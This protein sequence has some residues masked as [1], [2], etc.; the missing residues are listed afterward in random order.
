M[1][2]PNEKS[3][4][5]DSKEWKTGRNQALDTMKL[6]KSYFSEPYGDL[7]NDE[8]RKQFKDWALY[9]LDLLLKSYEDELQAGLQKPD[10]QAPAG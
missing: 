7:E 5:Q 4:G 3:L 10:I 1:L 9:N 2:T 6:V 8:D